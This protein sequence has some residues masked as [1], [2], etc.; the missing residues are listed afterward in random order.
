MCEIDS[1]NLS[2]T[3]ISVTFKGNFDI[4]LWEIYLYTVQ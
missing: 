4:M 3:P 1:N 2:F